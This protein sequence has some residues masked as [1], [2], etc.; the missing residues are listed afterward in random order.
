MLDGIQQILKADCRP[1]AGKRSKKKAPR[2][3]VAERLIRLRTAYK[4]FTTTA[5]ADRLGVSLQRVSN[6]ENGLP[7][8]KDLAFLIAKKFQG[9]PPTWLW[10]GSTAGMDVQVAE[11]LGELVPSGKEGTKKGR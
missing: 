2:N 9:V 6:V 10:F 11:L 3:D 4:L 7:L 1:M 5:L 8:G